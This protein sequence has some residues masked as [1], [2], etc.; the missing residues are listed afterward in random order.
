MQPFMDQ[1]VVLSLN[2]S[3]GSSAVLFVGGEL[4]AAVEEERLNRIKLTRKFPEKSV[5][6]VL[7]LAAVEPKDV[8]RV[9]VASRITP[10]WISMRFLQEYHEKEAYNCFSRLLYCVVAE[11]FTMR[12]TGLIHLE[13]GLVKSFV[14]D[15]LKELGIRAPITMYDHHLSHCY[16]AYSTAPFDHSLALSMDAMGDGISCMVALGDAGQL[17]QVDE[18]SGFRTPAFIYSQVTQLLG[19]TPTKHEGKLTGLA[20]LGDP[21]KTESIVRKLMWLDGDRFGIATTSNK[22]HP[23]YVELMKHTPQDIAAG[24][25][26]VFEDI[27]VQF[28]RQCLRKYNRHNIVL[29]GG[30]FANVKLNQRIHGIP[31]VDNIFVFPNMGDGGLPCGAGFAYYKRKPRPLENVY[32]GR[33]YDDNYCEKALINSGLS[34]R[35]PAD[36]E[37]NVANMLAHGKVVARHS[38]RMEYGPR[39]LG[40][41]SI[42]YQASDPSVNAWLNKHL[43]RTEFMPFAPSTIAEHAG[44]YYKNVEG[45][46]ETAKYMTITFD[47]TAKCKEKQPACVHVDNTARPQL[48][49]ARS[50]PSYYRILKNYYDLTGVPTILNTSFNVHEEPIVSTPEDAIKSYRQCKFDALA[51]GPFLVD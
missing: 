36:I 50:N 16:S 29:A 5:L 46:C 1:D 23:V 37:M 43:K 28:A 44:D 22:D 27:I 6:D 4:V 42:L 20:A 38:G 34:Y 12:Q 26:F 40:N 45:A 49:D 47:C 3:Q 11:Q 8:C 10:N 48:V 35:R 51:L 15:R 17:R 31:E 18:M 2:L 7:S 21:G 41:R 39:A 33:S 13:G 14:A 9:L 24:L 32:L 30:V 19:F 25:Q